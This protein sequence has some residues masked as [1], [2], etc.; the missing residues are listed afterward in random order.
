ME[1]G[2]FSLVLMNAER[3]TRQVIATLT[4][5]AHLD[6]EARAFIRDNLL[7]ERLGDSRR[8]QAALQRGFVPAGQRVAFLAERPAYLPEPPPALASGIDLEDLVAAFATGLQALRTAGP[9]LDLVF[10]FT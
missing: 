10:E 1:R 2:S 7:A 5:P 6:A 9:G 3:N 8:A 4:W